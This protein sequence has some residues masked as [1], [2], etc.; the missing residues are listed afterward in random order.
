M[1]RLG[2]DNASRVVLYSAQNVYWAARVWWLLRLFGF[3]N[4]AVLNGGWQKWGRE[5]RPSEVGPARPRSPSHFVIRAQRERELV[6]TKAEVLA[7]IGDPSVC[8]INALPA[9]QHL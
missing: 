1:S 5:G 7:A 9:D 3:D 4:A 2:I 6:A 8:T